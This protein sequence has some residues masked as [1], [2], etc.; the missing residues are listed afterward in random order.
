[1]IYLD[2]AATSYPKPE[3]V[4]KAMSEYI[5]NIGSNINR[6]VYKNS[7]EAGLMAL[8]L[9]ESL[10]RLFNFPEK[11]SHVIL[12]P[13][14][15]WSL[16]MVING[17]LR[18]GDHCIVSSMEH[19]AVMRPLNSLHGIEI[20]R[21]PS[22]PDG[23]CDISSVESLIKSNTR[24]LIMSHVSNV[25]GCIQNIEVIGEICERHN[26][27]FVLDAAQSAGHLSVDFTKMKLSGL[28]VPAHK[29]LLG[30]SGIG[31]L[32][33]N[34][35]LAH[36]LTPIVSGGTGSASDT[37]LTPDYLPDRFEPGT[38]NIPGIYGW[39]SSLD[40]IENTGLEKIRN[41]EKRL[42]AEFLSGLTA[43]ENIIVYGPSNVSLRTGVVS[44]NL[45]NMDNATASFR[46]E[47]EFDIMTRCGLHCAPSAHKT[48]GTY[49]NGTLRFS[50][51]IFNSTKDIDTVLHALKKISEE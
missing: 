30:P 37:E 48:L 43:L 42:C 40:Y 19:N 34:N 18:S 23:L 47:T 15:T 25:C 50:F 41:H 22:F 16:N 10:K 21:I 51:N 33:I 6:S 12:T 35:A 4:S 36:A 28:C 1:M 45:K 3:D 20:S 17:L 46:L 7:Q 29:G 26:I 8:S 14:A 31:A 5:C 38:P 39:K 32:L 2:N 49:P 24:L 13:G 44:V 27:F 9:R 11:P